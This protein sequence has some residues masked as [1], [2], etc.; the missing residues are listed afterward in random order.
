MYV[1]II[2]LEERVKEEK[3]KWQ[4]HI[5]RIKPNRIP[6]IILK[7]KP[8]GHRDIGSGAELSY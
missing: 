5:L 1:I 6:K 8:I 3:E 7:Q 2:H 4:L